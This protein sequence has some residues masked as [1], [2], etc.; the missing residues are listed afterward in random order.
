MVIS[1]LAGLVVYDGGRRV[2][3]YQMLFRNQLPR[4]LASRRLTSLR[5]LD[6]CTV[7]VD[8]T[9][10]K[11]LCYSNHSI[12]SIRFHSVSVSGWKEQEGHVLRLALEPLCD[13]MDVPLSTSS[14]KRMETC[15]GCFDWEECSTLLLDDRC[16]VNSLEKWQEEI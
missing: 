5:Q 3:P 12:T 4:E 15:V 9:A 16:P 13:V 11:V 2:E 14:I 1:I 6:L 7:E 10:L 8:Y